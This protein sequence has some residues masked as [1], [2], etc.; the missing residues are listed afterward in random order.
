M[1]ILRPLLFINLNSFNMHVRKNEKQT[2]NLQ[3]TEGLT[4]TLLPDVSHEFLMTTQDVARGYGL[5]PNTLRSHVSQNKEE[6]VEGKHFMKAVQILNTLPKGAQPHQTMWTKRGIV[7]LGFFIK[8]GRAKMFRD[9]AE[10][11]VI[12]RL[13]AQPAMPVVIDPVDK[14]MELALESNELSVRKQLYQNYLELRNYTESLKK[15]V[16]EYKVNHDKWSN[17]VHKKTKDYQ[18]QKGGQA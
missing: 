7:R 10:D 17:F 9:W 1:H 12:E 13:N 5:S 2:M 4:V 18:S 8:T 15:E 6:L 16:A 11:L 14:L 3:V